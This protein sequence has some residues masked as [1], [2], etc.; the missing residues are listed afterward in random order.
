METP[1]LFRSYESG[2]RAVD[3][4]IIQACRATSAAETYFPHITIGDQVYTDG[5][6]GRNNPV[7]E[8]VREAKSY[9]RQKGYKVRKPTCI[10]SIGTGLMSLINLKEAEQKTWWKRMAVTERIGLN[11]API[12]ADIVSNCEEAHRRMLE[13]CHNNDETYLYFRFNVDRGLEKIPLDEYEAAGDIESATANY[14]RELSFDRKPEDCVKMLRFSR[15]PHATRLLTIQR[16]A[17]SLRQQARDL[18]EQLDRMESGQWTGESRSSRANVPVIFAG[19]TNAGRDIH[20][21][22]S[23]SGVGGNLRIGGG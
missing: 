2:T 13:T 15:M 9:Y 6:L 7:D 1:V 21:T 17:A 5:G 4:T 3:C 18:D 19:S 16:K 11:V 12:L 14:L 10:V 23:I 22:G 20:Q 8:L